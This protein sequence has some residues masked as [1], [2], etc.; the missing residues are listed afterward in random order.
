ML[1]TTSQNWEEFAYQVNLLTLFDKF[2]FSY[3]IQLNMF[4]KLTTVQYT[5]N[6][7]LQLPDIIL[8]NVTMDTLTFH[9]NGINSLEELASK[10]KKTSFDTDVKSCNFVNFAE[11]NECKDIHT[12]SCDK[13]AACV[14][15]FDGY[16]CLC[17][18]GYHDVSSS[19]NLRP[20]RVCTLG[21]L[22]VTL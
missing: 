1:Q 22:E 12:H 18:D 7:Y 3:L 14:K 15:K 8:V 4:V 9:L 20:G 17:Q 11:K 5:A 6:A 21:E 10:V 19:A 2:L 16:T 13:N